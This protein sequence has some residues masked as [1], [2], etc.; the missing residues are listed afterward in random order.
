MLFHRFGTISHILAS[1]ELTCCN[2]KARY[3]SFPSLSK[4][5][6]HS[7]R[8]YFTR[9][10]FILSMKKFYSEYEKESQI[11]G[12]FYRIWLNILYATFKASKHFVNLNYCYSFDHRLKI[13]PRM[14]LFRGMLSTLWDSY[15]NSKELKTTM[16]AT[17][18]TTG[19][20]EGARP[21]TTLHVMLRKSKL[22]EPSTWLSRNV[23]SAF[24]PRLLK[25][26]LKQVNTFS[27]YC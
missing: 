5:F 12:Q 24:L 2:K 18:R 14:R 16:T 19:N 13:A 11:H 15:R 20:L 3:H 17:V 26:A 10:T 21:S 6:W 4:S 8:S 9:V 25:M 22:L 23:S 1:T 27:E 7:W